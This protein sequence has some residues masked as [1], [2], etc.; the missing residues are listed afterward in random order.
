MSIFAYTLNLTCMTYLAENV[1]LSLI[2]LLPFFV[3]LAALT[4]ENELLKIQQLIYIS[5]S[6]FGILLLTNPETFTQENRAR[7]FAW[8]SVWGFMQ[9]NWLMVLVAIASNTFQALNYMAGR[10]ISRQVHSCVETMYIG[11]VSLMVYSIG[12]LFFKPSYFRFWECQFSLEQVLFIIVTS[13]LY[14]IS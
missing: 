4:L 5:L 6:Y 1:F 3:G 13:V 9:E 2:M 14:Y 11:I 12:I 10:R 7:I 8:S